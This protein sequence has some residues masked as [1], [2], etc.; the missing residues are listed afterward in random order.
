MLSTT[1]RSGRNP[2]GSV[3]SRVLDAKVH[4]LAAGGAVHVCGVAR[5]QQPSC[6]VGIGNAV[7]DPEPRA[8]H[9]VLDDHPPSAE[10]AL[11]EQLLDE[12]DR[13]ALRRVR[14]GRDDAEDAFVGE[15][16]DDGQPGGGPEQIDLVGRHF[17]GQMDIG[18]RERLL[19]VTSVETDPGLF[20]HGAANAVCADHVPSLYG[21]AVVER[22]R[23]P[24]GVLAD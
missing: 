9:H 24:V 13:R 6:A 22:R 17:A 5:E 4:A 19:V 21:V 8:P 15:R 7:M 10:A 2:R 11:V 14:G 16:R 12:L 20:A 23:H 18:E 3:A 1:L